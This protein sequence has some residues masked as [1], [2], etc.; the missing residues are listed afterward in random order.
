MQ[1]SVPVINMNHKALIDI[2]IEG[3]Q[4]ITVIATATTFKKLQSLLIT[5]EPKTCSNIENILN[6][7]RNLENLIHHDINNII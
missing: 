6:I 2:N 4:H 7:L 1:K 5:L 3:F